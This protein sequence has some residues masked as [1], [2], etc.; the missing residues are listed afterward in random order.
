MLRYLHLYYSL[1]QRSHQNGCERGRV[2]KIVIGTPD[3][4]RVGLTPPGTALEIFLV[5]V[6]GGRSF[7][8]LAGDSEGRGG[9]GWGR[10][11]TY[12]SEHADCHD[13]KGYTI[14]ITEINFALKSHFPAGYQENV[15]MQKILPE[16]KTQQTNKQKCNKLTPTSVCRSIPTS[17]EY[18][19]LKYTQVC[20]FL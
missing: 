9:V 4:S 5:V 12:K 16:Q 20:C 19:H 18:H 14:L 2:W 3:I 17:P 10:I 15:R 13:N 11:L 6:L 7:D 8:R 1:R